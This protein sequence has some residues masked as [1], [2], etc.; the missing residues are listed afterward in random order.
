M[1]G[2]P[3]GDAPFRHGAVRDA[4]VGNGRPG[5]FLQELADEKA[6]AAHGLEGQGPDVHGD[7]EGGAHG[8]TLRQEGVEVNQPFP[9]S[10][11]LT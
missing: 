4:D 6:D 8:A 7:A 1:D 3:R 9:A 11:A 2:N 5:Y 10:V